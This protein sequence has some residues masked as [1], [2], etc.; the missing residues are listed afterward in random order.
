M[1]DAGW[2]HGIHEIHIAVLKELVTTA[3]KDNG[4]KLANV[5]PVFS[6][7]PLVSSSVCNSQK[8]IHWQYY[9]M[10]FQ[11]WKAFFGKGASPLSIGRMQSAKVKFKMLL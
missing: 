6:G 1:L 7:S 10:Y 9:L 5:F 4:A 3:G 11:G 8:A 2:T